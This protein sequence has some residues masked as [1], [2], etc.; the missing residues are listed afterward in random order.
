MPFRS[1]LPCLLLCTGMLVAGDVAATDDMQALTPAI[2]PVSYTHLDVYKRQLEDNALEYVKGGGNVAIVYPSD[3][4][5]AVADGI[6]LVK[7][8]PNEANAKVF[9]D[10]LLSK[11][12]QEFLV[13]EIGRRSV[14]SDVAG[15]GLKPMSE[16]KLV[17]YDLPMVAAKRTEWL[18]QFRK[19]VQA[20]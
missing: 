12:V 4:T 10:W 8:A 19:A 17:K 5:S 11:P 7:G 15:T 13:A 9:L 18:A 1:F 6:A 2:A 20:R 3:G 16:I 14:R